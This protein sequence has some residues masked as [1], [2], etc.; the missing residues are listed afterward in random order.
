[1]FVAASEETNM[2]VMYTFKSEY[3]IIMVARNSVEVLVAEVV[4]SMPDHVCIID[5][6]NIISKDEND[7]PVRKGSTKRDS[8]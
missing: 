4:P 1:M 5:V 3:G 7:N 6:G 8:L 2:R